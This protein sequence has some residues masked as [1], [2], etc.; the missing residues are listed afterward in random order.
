M[1]R[2]RQDGWRGVGVL[3]N[4]HYASIYDRWVD[5][6]KIIRKM[7]RVMVFIGGSPSKLNCPE[8]QSHQNEKNTARGAPLT[9]NGYSTLFYTETHPL[10]ATFFESSA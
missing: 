3:N 7:G 4:E 10:C 6:L 1:Y 5:P 9:K 8:K 2:L